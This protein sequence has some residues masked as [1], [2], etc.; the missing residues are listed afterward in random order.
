MGTVGTLGGG[1]VS[2]R[3]VRDRVSGVETVLNV[4]RKSGEV[5]GRPGGLGSK[6]GE[7]EKNLLGP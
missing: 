7:F 1:L 4:L 3:M 5:G 2:F 6:F